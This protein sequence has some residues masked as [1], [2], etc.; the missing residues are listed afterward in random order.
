MILIAVILIFTSCRLPDA[1]EYLD[2]YIVE[3]DALYIGGYQIFILDPPEQ[4]TPG[5]EALSDEQKKIYT[6]A[7]RALESGETKFV[8]TG[9]DYRKHLDI[10]GYALHTMLYDHPEFFWL[11][12]EAAANAEYPIGSEIGNVTIELS[13]Y[14]HWKTSDLASARAEFD[15]ATDKIVSEAEKKTDIFE[16]VLYVHDIIIKSVTYD[17]E[18][19]ESETAADAKTDAFSNTAYGALVEGRAL[20]GGYARAFSHIMHLL[21]IGSLLITGEADGGPHAWNLVNL[22]NEYYH[23]DLTWDDADEDNCKVFYNYFCVTDKE[24]S[25]THTSD[26]DCS[27]ATS[28]RYNYYIYR[29]LVLNEYSFDAVREMYSL[30]DDKS[31]FTFKC[32][33]HDVFDAAIDDLV[34]NKMIDKLNSSQSGL[35]YVDEEM[36]II[37]FVF[38]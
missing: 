22:D 6:A 25:K 29:S 23:I 18:S 1:G 14:D 2:P 7:L 36:R 17:H 8:Y 9:V 38:D 15:K 24:I 12:G 35:Y 31:V 5:Y 13:V 16:K 34:E 21:G 4:K 3:T 30:C 33:S 26:N 32:A 28:D 20:C 10:Y 11:N 37:T 27:A 19:L